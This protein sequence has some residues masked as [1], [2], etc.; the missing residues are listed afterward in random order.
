MYDTLTDRPAVWI[1]AAEENLLIIKLTQI[2]SGASVRSELGIKLYSY[3][4]YKDS[5]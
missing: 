4:I 1:G 3:H 2:F 5:L